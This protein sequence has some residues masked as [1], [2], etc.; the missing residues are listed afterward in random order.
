MKSLVKSTWQET[1]SRSFR[2]SRNQ[3]KGREAQLDRSEIKMLL[4]ATYSESAEVRCHAANELCL[5]HIQGNTLQVW[6]RL[7]E[8]IADP[9]P[10]VRNIILHTLGDGS[11]NERETEVIAAIESRYNDTD[12]KFRRKVRNFLAVYRRTG[13]WNLL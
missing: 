12:L 5:C 9:D 11:P 2:Q 10:K 3:T 13:K 7:L 8:M 4:N 1:V 6:D